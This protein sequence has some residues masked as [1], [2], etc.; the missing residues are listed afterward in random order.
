MLHLPATSSPSRSGLRPSVFLSV[1]TLPFS[2]RRATHDMVIVLAGRM[3][4][5]TRL[6]TH[7]VQSLLETT[8]ITMVTK[9]RL[10]PVASA[11]DVVH[12]P[13]I[14]NWQFARHSSGNIANWFILSTGIGQ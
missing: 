8:T 2:K 11:H 7:F 3:D 12:R 1:F 4:L 13:G 6:E 14:L 10:A 9:D 5:P